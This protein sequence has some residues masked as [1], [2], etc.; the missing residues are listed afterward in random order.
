MPVNTPEAP[1]TSNVIDFTEPHSTVMPSSEEY[2]KTGALPSKED[3]ARTEAPAKEVDDDSSQQAQPGNQDDS[4]SSAAEPTAEEQRRTEPRA[5]E[6]RWQKREREIKQLR[7]ENARLKAQG[8]QPR[9]DTQQVSQPAAQSTTQQASQPGGAQGNPEPQIEDVDPATGKPKYAKL[10]DFLSAH[11][12]WNREE[13]VREYDQRSTQRQQETERTQIGKELADHVSKARTAHPD[14]DDVLQAVTDTK[15]AD[16]RPTIFY[17]NGSHIDNFL[18][19]QPDRGVALLYHCCANV[20]D[21]VIRAIFARTPKGTHY[22]LSNM[23][24]IS[25]LA[26][27]A[28]TLAG[29]SGRPSRR[30]AAAAAATTAGKGSEGEGEGEGDELDDF[31]N[32]GGEHSSARPISQA[33]RPAHQT[34]GRGSVGKDPVIEAVETGDSET[35][36]REVNRAALNRRKKGKS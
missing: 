34:S 17:T 9:S 25:R 36:M 1:A 6:K 33:P 8:T 24:Q 16:G 21:P 28:H 35:Y 10:T 15:E 18:L 32:E 7:E 27:L 20:E 14:Y 23:E 11:A 4:A 5:A 13:A 3:R 26:V 29:G 2:R 30:A 22:Q 31:G 19:S 12:K